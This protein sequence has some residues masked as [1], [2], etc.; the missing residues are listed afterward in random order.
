VEAAVRQARQLDSGET[1]VISA[2]K[3]STLEPLLDK[4]GAVLARNLVAA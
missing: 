4:A 3:P 2:V 1:V